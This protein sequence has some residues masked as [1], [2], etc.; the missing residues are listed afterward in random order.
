MQQKQGVCLVP[1]YFLT[2]LVSGTEYKGSSN[3]MGVLVQLST[4]WLPLFLR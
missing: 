4:W 3:A 1:R 2:Y